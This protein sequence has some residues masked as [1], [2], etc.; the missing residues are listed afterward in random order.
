MEAFRS[1]REEFILVEMVLWGI[2]DLTSQ[3]DPFLHRLREYL[4]STATDDHGSNHERVR[5]LHCSN[6]PFLEAFVQPRNDFL[7]RAAMQVQCGYAGLTLMR[8]SERGRLG[9][10][11]QILHLA[12]LDYEIGPPRLPADAGSGQRILVDRIFFHTLPAALV[13]RFWRLALDVE[14]V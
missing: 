2:A 4:G 10:L 13:L 12:D 9:R 8:R 7:S 3:F 6:H 11:V 5:T 1:Q 14:S